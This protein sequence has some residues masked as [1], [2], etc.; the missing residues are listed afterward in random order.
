[1][2]FIDG[3]YSTKLC[4]ENERQRQ[5][6]INVSFLLIFTIER[7][8]ITCKVRNFTKRARDRDRERDRERENL[9]ERERNV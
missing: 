2:S 7:Y 5:R 8:V 3:A 6:E 4:K 9:I 1:M